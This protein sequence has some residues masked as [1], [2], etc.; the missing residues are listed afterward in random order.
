MIAQYRVIE[1]LYI[2]KQ[3]EASTQLKES[4]TDLH[5]F[6]LRFLVKAKRLYTKGSTST[7]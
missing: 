5:V 2:E 1:R 7:Q 3:F 4:I 6:V